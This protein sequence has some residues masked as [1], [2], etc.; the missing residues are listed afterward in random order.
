MIKPF[1][2]PRTGPELAATVLGRRADP[3]VPRELCE[4]VLRR[5]RARVDL[6]MGS[7]SDE[8]DREEAV[9]S[10]F[11]ELMQ[12]RDE[13]GVLP[14]R[15]PSIEQFEQRLRRMASE[16]FTSGGESLPA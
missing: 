3:E 10:L 12:M 11:E 8:Q 15:F 13:N 7:Q 1:E 4:A 9:M 6:L 16:R 2:K 14:V 5:I